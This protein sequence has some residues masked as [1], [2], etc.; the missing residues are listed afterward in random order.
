[1]VEIENF[2]IKFQSQP[3]IGITSSK[4]LHLISIPLA[5]QLIQVLLQKAVLI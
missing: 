1:M 3:F 2:F 4:V 5:I